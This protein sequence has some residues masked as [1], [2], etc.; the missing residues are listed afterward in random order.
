MEKLNIDWDNGKVMRGNAEVMTLDEMLSLI[1][2]A[3]KAYDRFR[4]PA[5]REFL[6]AIRER[7]GAKVTFDDTE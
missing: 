5:S 6:N 1:G 4:I 2:A 3:A 7:I